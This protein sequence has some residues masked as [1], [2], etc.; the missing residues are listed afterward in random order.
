MEIP[1]LILFEFCG[2]LLVKVEKE[3]QLIVG[4]NEIRMELRNSET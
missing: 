2:R 4:G 1:Q 3:L